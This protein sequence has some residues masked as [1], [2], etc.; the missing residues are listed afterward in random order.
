MPIVDGAVTRI[1]I[2]VPTGS[3]RGLRRSVK[4]FANATRAVGRVTRCVLVVNGQARFCWL[5]F[6]VLQVTTIVAPAGARVTERSV[7]CE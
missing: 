5:R 6:F 3:R 4:S 7:T 2:T 1:V